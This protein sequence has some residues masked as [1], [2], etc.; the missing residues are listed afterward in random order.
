[1]SALEERV[2]VVAPTG[3]DAVVTRDVLV[4]AGLIAESCDDLGDACARIEE[5][6]GAL[7]LTEEA[8]SASGL[9]ELS[10][11]LSAQSPV[12]RHPHRRL[13]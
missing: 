9:A 2:L 3:R 5:G 13:D 7:L 8:L 12:V 4:N 6:A 10:K 1:M 11:A